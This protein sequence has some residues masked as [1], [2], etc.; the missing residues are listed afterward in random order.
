MQEALL[1]ADPADPVQQRAVVSANRYSAIVYR[2]NEQ[3]KQAAAA[4]ERA[5]AIA[6]SVRDG[7]RADAAAA[8]LWLLAVEVQAQIYADAGR[9][10]D[11]LALGEAMK[12]EYR[13]LI[14]LAG[15]A[16]GMH[17]NFYAALRT[18]GGDY[19]NVHSYDRACTTWREADEH[20]TWLEKNVQLT[21][22]DRGGR[23]DITEYLA[24]ACDGGGPRA[25]LGPLI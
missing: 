6:R 18:I 15:D 24:K 8:L 2:T 9:T 5:V 23:A 11:T 4:I 17:R 1:A 13:R 3:D 25:G 22:T 14:P 20:L 19:Y 10:A 12:R 7:D 21:A 16:A